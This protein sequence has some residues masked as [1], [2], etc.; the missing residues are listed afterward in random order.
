VNI[1]SQQERVGNLPE[2]ETI[3]IPGQKSPST[4]KPSIF[5]SLLAGTVA[6]IVITVL[7]TVIADRFRDLFIALLPVKSAP[8]MTMTEKQYAKELQNQKRLIDSQKKKLKGFTPVQ[9]YLII[10]SSENKI[11]LMKGNKVLHEGLCSTGSYTVLKTSDGKEK[12]VFQT[13][14]GMLRVQN[15]LVDPVWRMPD[16]AFIEEGL[17]V[18]PP[19]AA[20]RYEY[21]VLGD[22]ALDLGRGYLIHGTLY[23]R[24]LGMPVTHGCVRLGD[25]ELKIVYDS[26]SI[27][28]RVFIY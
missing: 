7:L 23:K 10:N 25:Q 2:E 8:A 15:K 22:Y 12:W 4:R 19:F 9:N 16:W 24:F 5:I 3:S 21:N 20:E 28:S 11:I 6:I 13:P 26:L 1:D 27:G 18:P 17:P 14:R